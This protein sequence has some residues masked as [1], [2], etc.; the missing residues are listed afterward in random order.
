MAETNSYSTLMLLSDI[1]NDLQVEYES[2]NWVRVQE[3]IDESIKLSK[4][5]YGELILE[6]KIVKG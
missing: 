1:N 3:L 4:V 6:K 5:F 2:G